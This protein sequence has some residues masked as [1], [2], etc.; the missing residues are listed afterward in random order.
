MWQ[1]RKIFGFDLS[2]IWRDITFKKYVIVQNLLSL[3]LNLVVVMGLR[4][5]IANREICHLMCPLVLK[6]EVVAAIIYV[7]VLY[8]E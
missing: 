2:V 6:T 5:N 8:L 3:M 1:I 4:E 7:A